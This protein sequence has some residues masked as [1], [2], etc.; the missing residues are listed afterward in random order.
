MVPL[1]VLNQTTLLTAYP[2]GL[3]GDG[4][5]AD[6]IYVI[7]HNDGT[8]PAWMTTLL[9]TEYFGNRSG[10]KI[11]STLID[12][13]LARNV[14]PDDEALGTDARRTVATIILHRYGDKWERLA[15]LFTAEYNPIENY[16][17]T[18]TDTP[19]ISRKHRVSEDFAETSERTVKED[20]TETTDNEAN[21]DIFGFNSTTP[22]PSG[23][24]DNQ[25]VY[26][27][28]TDPEDNVVTEEKTQTGYREETETGTRTLRRS[29]NIGIMTV[30][31]MAEQEITL[32]KHSFFDIV[33]DDVDSVISSNFYNL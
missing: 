32:R 18:E 30:Q 21:T 9:D 25:Q 20:V 3:N 5:F 28:Q 23:R 4:V 10:E 6:L 8:A 2:S 33:F 11:V 16:D 13:L 7:E 31:Q 17:M 19:N 12:H 22:V 14:D 15:D 29:G 26:R 24:G 1:R 27:R